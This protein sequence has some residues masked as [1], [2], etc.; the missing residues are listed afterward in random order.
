MLLIC[1]RVRLLLLLKC[2][3]KVGEVTELRR[4]DRLGAV[5]LGGVP[6][7]LPLAATAAVAV[8]RGG[9]C[10]RVGDDG[11]GPPLAAY[12][13]LELL[14]QALCDLR[15]DAERRLQEVDDERARVE[16]EAALAPEE[17]LQPRFN[18]ASPGNRSGPLVPE[19]K[20][21]NKSVRG[22]FGE[23]TF[24]YQFTSASHPDPEWRSG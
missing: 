24:N 7:A 21:F 20:L 19:V 10:P 12:R 14:L 17:R 22:V 13:L 2:L 5:H 8:D 23:V 6:V 16:G 9:L 18:R 11:L 4:H 3:L 1:V 15:A